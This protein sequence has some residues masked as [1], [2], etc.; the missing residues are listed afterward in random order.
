[1][2]QE[3]SSQSVPVLLNDRVDIALAA[4]LDGVH[5]PSRGIPVNA[6]RRFAPPELLVGRSCH[7]LPDVLAAQDEGADYVLLSP[8]F[9]TLSKPGVEAM[10]L[11]ELSRITARVRIPVVALG[12]MKAEVVRKTLAAGA[13]GIGGIRCFEDPEQSRRM[14]NSI[15]HGTSPD[16]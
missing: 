6:I 14:A 9:P 16:R 15:I 7:S 2:K 12:G 8:V 5:L 10:G 11:E 3:L 4:G 1:L 13:A